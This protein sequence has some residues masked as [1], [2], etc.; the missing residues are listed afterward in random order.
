MPSLPF[1]GQTAWG[2]ILNT[3]LTSLSAQATSTQTTLQN[4]AAN[5]PTDP[6]GDRAYAQTLVSPF[7]TGLNTANG[8]VKLNGSGTI[9]PALITASSAIGGMY[10]AVVDAVSM[11]GVTAGTNTDQS[12][13]L[14]SAMNYVA[15][16]GGGIVY[17]GP[18]TFS[19][20]NPV[21]IGS[22]TWVLMSRGTT[23]QRIPGS[24]N[25]PYIFTN[26]QLTSTSTP[27]NNV[28]ITGGKLDAVGSFT[29]STSCT[30]IE[31]FQGS[32]HVVDNVSFYAPFS[33]SHAIEF[34]G[35]AGGTVSNC[36]FGGVQSNSSPPSNSAI[37]INYSG[38]S[39]SP[40][41]LNATL[42]NNQQCYVI[43]VNDNNVTLLSGGNS[44]GTYGCLVGSDVSNS[45]S[46]S[47]TVVT[48]TGNTFG[49]PAQNG[50]VYVNSASWNNVTASGNSWGNGDGTSGS[51]FSPIPFDSWIESSLNSGWSNASGGYPLQY[52]LSQDGTLTLIGYIN[53][54]GSNPTGTITT[55]PY[56]PTHPVYQQV[57]YANS[58]QAFTVQV[59]TNGRVSFTFAPSGITSAPVFI[60]FTFPVDFSGNGTWT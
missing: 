32:S 31:L 4:H 29:V 47:P 52:K 57:A 17:I 59:Q 13:A 41:G 2:D 18:G 6:H 38:S 21:Y 56:H 5:S 25:A 50:P 20:A 58:T 15:G 30:L 23:I 51:I 35:V 14:Q 46:I 3:Y 48:I 40:A 39:N 43:T 8:L 36:A 12:A 54:N 33:N 55:L 60:N 22:N 27:A 10:S 7:T 49:V 26:I 45:S 1:D 28:K 53:V 19:V 34:N 11:F 24:P 16:L 44:Y 9:P 37:L 42:Y